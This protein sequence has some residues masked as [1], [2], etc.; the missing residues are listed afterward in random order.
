MS[1]QVLRVTLDDNDPLIQS[2]VLGQIFI[3]SD[4]GAVDYIDAD[5]I[6]EH[7]IMFD[8][9]A[10]TNIYMEKAVYDINNNGIADDCDNLGGV[11]A[12]QYATQVWVTANATGDMTKSV[13]DTNNNGI[14]DDSDRLGGQLPAYYASLAYV[15][16]LAVP[17]YSELND[18]DFTAQLAGDVIMFNGTDWIN[19]NLIDQGTF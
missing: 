12:N 8:P 3:N 7:I 16:S 4:A 15:N 11:P 9:S 2:K 17:K 6:G 5:G 19:T 14:V 1:N 10:T 13:Y 18:A